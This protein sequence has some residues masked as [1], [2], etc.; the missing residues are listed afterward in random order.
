[1]LLTG[2]VNVLNPRTVQVKPPCPTPSP[3]RLIPRQTKLLDSPGR[4]T[5]QCIRLETGRAA[6]TGGGLGAR[7]QAEG[8]FYCHGGRLPCK[9]VTVPGVTVMV[10][11]LAER[12][13]IAKKRATLYHHG[14]IQNSG[15]RVSGW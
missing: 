2:S 6:G 11:T 4:C 14:P 10:A 9:P 12:G 5:R 1:M 3:T 8:R 13:E 15:E 7:V